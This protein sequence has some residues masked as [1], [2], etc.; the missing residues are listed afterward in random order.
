MS[1]DSILQEIINIDSSN[2]FLVYIIDR[3]KRK[4]YR[5]I[6]ISQHNRYDLYYIEKIL[7]AIYFIAGESIF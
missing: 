2:K 3:I 1:N 5:G 7:E 6:H 4:D